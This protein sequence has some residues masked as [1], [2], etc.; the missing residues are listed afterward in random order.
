MVD[1]SR[2]EA[3]TD[4]TGGVGSTSRA[5]LMDVESRYL[6]FRPLGCPVMA[7]KHFFNLTKIFWVDLCG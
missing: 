2:E 3:L 4:D 7:R 6:G 5:F 1:S